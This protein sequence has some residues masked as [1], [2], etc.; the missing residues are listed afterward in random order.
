MTG[1]VPCREATGG[2]P[3][4]YLDK[5]YRPEPW[6]NKVGEDST[7][8]K[9]QTGVRIQPALTMRSTR[10]SSIGPTGERSARTSFQRSSNAS[11][12]SAGRAT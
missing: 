8:E 5:L 1:V 12:P 11:V 3:A 7:G 2:P 4:H 6:G 9:Q 10:N